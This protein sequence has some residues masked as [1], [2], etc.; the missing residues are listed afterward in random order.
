MTGTFEYAHHVGM[1][2]PRSGSPRPR[3]DGDAV[4]AVDG[5]AILAKFRRDLS[6]DA[7]R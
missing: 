4:P 7:T 3:G 6:D 2:R 1:S 5:V